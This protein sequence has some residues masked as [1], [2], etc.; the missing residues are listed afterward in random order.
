MPRATETQIAVCASTGRQLL[1]AIFACVI[2]AMLAFGENRH[3]GDW[4]EA[5]LWP[6]RT[7]AVDRTNQG[8]AAAC[9]LARQGGTGDDHEPGSGAVGSLS[10]AQ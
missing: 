3:F 9:Y 10:P 1:G 7:Q 8:T 2:L 5:A 4:P 6:G